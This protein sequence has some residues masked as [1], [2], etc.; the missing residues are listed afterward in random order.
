MGY[1]RDNYANI[2]Y[3][4]AEDQKDGLRRAQLGAVHAIAAHFV[5]RDDPAI[6]TMPTGSGKTAVLMITPFLQCAKRVLVL[7]PSRLVRNQISE[8]FASL[9]TLRKIKVID[10]SLPGPKVKE[11]IEKLSD[12]SKWNE[13]EGY[14]VI[15]GTPRS[16]SPTLEGNAP[17]PENFFDLILVDEAHHSPALS[18]SELINY[19]PNAK[20]VLFTATPFR[21]D[22]KEIVGKFVFSYTLADAHKDKVFGNIEYI[23]VNPQGVSN[24]IAIAIETEKQ[25]LI[26]RGN[27]LTHFIMVR[28]DSKKRANDLAKIYSDNT[29]L[30]L[31]LVHSGHS[32][33]TIKDTI[34]KLKDKELDGIICV[35][36]LGEGF[37]FPY[38]KIAAVHVPHR[39]LAV[40][41]Q[42]IGRFARTNAP[43]IGVAKFLAVPSEIEIETEKLFEEGATWQKIITNLSQSKLNQEMEVREAIASF[44]EPIIEEVD[45]EDLSLYSLAPYHHVKIYNIERDFDIDAVIGIPDN[46]QVVFQQI[47]PDLNTAIFITKEAEKPQWSTIKRFEHIRYDLFVVYYYEETSLLFIAASR[48]A[49]MLYQMIAESFTACK[50]YLLPVSAINKVLI[51]LANAEFFNIGMR[52]RVYNNNTESYRIITGSNAQKAVKATDGRLYNRGHI[53]GK[54]INPDGTSTTIGFSSSSKVWSNTTSQIP[55]LISWCK[56]LAVKISSDKEVKTNSGL[57]NLAVGEVVTSIPDGIIAAGWDKDVYLNSIIARYKTE[58]DVDMI[59]PL[60]NFDINIDRDNTN[61]EKITFILSAEGIEYPLNYSLN[62]DYYFQ[63]ASSSQREIIL[64]KGNTYSQNEINLIEYLN[65]KPLSFYFAD[66]SMIH[67]HQIYKNNSPTLFDR[68][69]IT[70]IGWDTVNVDIEKEIGVPISDGDKQSI[71]YYLDSVLQN[72]DSDV[73]FFDHGTGELADFLTIKEFDQYIKFE[74]YHCKGSGGAQPGNRVDDVY[75]VCGQVIKSVAWTNNNELLLKKILDRKERA[76]ED[77]VGA[78]RFRKGS[79][80][81]LRLVIQ[82]TRIKRSV[83]EII[84]VQPGITKSKAESKILGLLAA[85]NDYI[86]GGN[87]ERLKIIASD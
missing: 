62:S 80:E 22:K 68:N 40:T 74:F 25:F 78:S 41:L 73:V 6:I 60:V 52:N 19:F 20:K 59:T 26:D 31:K 70:T 42:F 69:Q 39:S 35:D 65:S 36:M 3:P 66:F 75:E 45:T 64:V 81:L 49:D 47:S 58:A 10:E 53:F 44:E 72:E 23:P 5:L 17:A 12:V 9:D 2:K 30:N 46:L 13:L 61:N 71:Q 55:E 34:K 37:D 79:E 14:D 54:G 15:I 21:R 84:A 87:C 43:D 33:K 63:K 1:F 4:I 77:L 82:N 51:D 86:I 50:A 48:K 7:T 28:T 18:W 83:Y 29:Q 16:I 56:M 32:Y 27:N 85:A 8:D 38:L 57:D 76:L 67:G 24:D 11:I